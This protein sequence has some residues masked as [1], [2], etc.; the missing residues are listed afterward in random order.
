LLID[1]GAPDGCSAIDDV[2]LSSNL[3][4]RD[5]SKVRGEASDI[6]INAPN[7][8]IIRFTKP[9]GILRDGIQHG[10][11]LSGRAGDHA[12]D[13]TRGRLPFQGL[14]KFPRLRVES[15][16]QGGVRCGR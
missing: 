12:E 2:T 11:K 16:L 7:Y 8:G 3:R 6:A 9:S 1:H 13:V 14:S 4:Y 15:F 10:L 5:R